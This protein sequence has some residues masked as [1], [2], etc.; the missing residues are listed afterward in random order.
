VTVRLSVLVLAKLPEVPER[1]TVP[2]PVVA[3][4]PAVSV[5]LLEVVAGLGLK[6]AVTPPGKPEADKVTAPLKPF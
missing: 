6:M 5:K 1:V 2:V 3:V 4:L